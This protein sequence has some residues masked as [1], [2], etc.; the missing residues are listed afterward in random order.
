MRIFVF[1][2]YIWIYTTLNVNLL[3]RRFSWIQKVF[4]HYIESKHIFISKEYWVF[5]RRCNKFKRRFIRKQ[6]IRYVSSNIQSLQP[7]GK[8]S[9]NNIYR[10]LTATTIRFLSYICLSVCFALAIVQT[11]I[12][13]HWYIN[14]EYI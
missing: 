11:N 4:Y 6:E 8:W 13:I 9:N 3:S 7:Q 1:I 10:A 14:Y 2:W 12:Y 5:S